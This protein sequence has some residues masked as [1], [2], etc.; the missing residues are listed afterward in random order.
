MTDVLV[1]A[2]LVD[3]K[4]RKTTLSAVGF[5]K[6]VAEGTGGAFD[7]L[8]IG[9]G[10]DPAAPRKMEAWIVEGSAKRARLLERADSIF[11]LPLRECAIAVE[12]DGVVELVYVR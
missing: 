6:T 4:A 5:A 10:A 11:D 9:E 7:I 3:G 1:V 12:R 2:E 8:A